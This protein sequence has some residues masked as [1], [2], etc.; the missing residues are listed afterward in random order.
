MSRLLQATDTWVLRFVALLS[1]VFL[2]CVLLQVFF[3][4]VLEES[5]VWSD[6][7]AR[8]SFVWSS[9]LAAAVIVGRNDHFTIPILVDLLPP[10]ARVA[11]EALSIA[12]CLVFAAIV[13][14]VSTDW[15]WR[16]L[17]ARSPVLQ[18]PQGLVYAV[19]PV[20]ALYMIVH[21]VA[22]AFR[23]ARPPSPPGA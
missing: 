9:F 21:L 3:R 22:R 1:A 6:E 23:L 11:I 15:S 7:L 2:A 18:F 16:M 13:L 4:Y 8:Y 17:D 5:L 20:S 10:R 19:V 14:K 12:L